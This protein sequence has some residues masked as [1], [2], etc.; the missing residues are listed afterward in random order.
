MNFV[1]PLQFKKNYS[2]ILIYDPCLFDQTL[3]I[4]LEFFGL[5]SRGAEAD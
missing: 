3:W 2:N 5:M 1:T 4:P